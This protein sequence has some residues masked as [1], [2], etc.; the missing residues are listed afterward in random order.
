MNLSAIYCRV[1]TDDQE[2]H[3][4]SLPYQ[5]ETCLKYAE[6]NG[7]KIGKKVNGENAIFLESFS[8]GYYDRPL[9]LELLSLVKTGKISSVIFTK[10]DRVARDQYVFQKIKKEI[11]EAGGKM[12]FA[13]EK[14]TG[15]TA[16]DSFMG[17]TIVG[18][19][20]WEREQIKRRTHA[21][22]VQHAR[23]NKWTFGYVPY[24][25]IRNP[26]TK[27]L[28]IYKDEA[29]IIQLMYR[30]YLD[31]GYTL[32]KIIRYLE[33]ESLPPPCLSSKE[34]TNQKSIA[35]SR[36]NTGGKWIPSTIYRIFERGEL[37]SGTYTAF[38]DIYKTEAGKT[39][40]IGQRPKTE[41]VIVSIP[42][43]ITPEQAEKV[44]E[45]M[46][47][48]RRFARKR[49][50]RSYPLRWKLFCD[51][52]NPHHNM[53][54]Y[55]WQKVKKGKDKKPLLDNE[56]NKIKEYYT[57]YRCGLYNLR[58]TS[59]ERH[60][61]NHISGIKIESLVF[62]AIKELFLAPDTLFGYVLEQGKGNMRK[63]QE[64]T[65]EREL[66]W[67]YSELLEKLK[68]LMKKN[69][70]IEELFVDGTISKDRM[71][72][73]KERVQEEENKIQKALDTEEKLLRQETFSAS[74]RES[75][76]VIRNE[77]KEDIGFFFL[78]ATDEEKR[79]LIELL[80][81]RIILTH[82]NNK[83]IIIRF[84]IPLDVSLEEKYMEDI[85]LF[86]NDG[87]GRETSI[88]VYN[89]PKIFP[90]GEIHTPIV[91]QEVQFEEPEKKKEE[92]KKK[93]DKWGKWGGAGKNSLGSAISKALAF[94]K[95]KYTLSC[96]YD[97]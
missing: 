4:S 94:L 3:G 36:K 34:T 42:P 5:V 53:I 20:E 76:E 17:S 48:N 11:E 35:N 92:N 60:C 71:K 39:K 21:G 38:R 18:F 23:E 55:P 31:E 93:N 26:Q 33:S 77:L 85:E 86:A 47:E 69:E 73:M 97:Q 59:E 64:G 78:E 45:K 51:C 66:E 72:E 2:S 24:G 61:K 41:W 57:N 87:Y 15:D 75:W 82:G 80:I 68:A 50:V 70:R 91:S 63:A 28:E 13:E 37:Y 90:L 27:Q 8:W 52:E 95:K 29:D 89:F 12:I 58:R 46:E 54:G 22:K 10:R 44:L 6:E 96:K 9:L 88:W 62:D 30:L 56:G 43:L 25:Y 16:I 19:A 40:L 1:S 7:L 49:S 83:H 84:K 65:K 14:L 81:E 32:D 74:A 67:D 79:S